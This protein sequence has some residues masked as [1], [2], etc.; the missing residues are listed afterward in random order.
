M[1]GSI[2]R[3]NQMEDMLEHLM[4]GQTEHFILAPWG[5]HC[6]QGQRDHHTAKVIRLLLLVFSPQPRAKFYNP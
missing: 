4:D 3:H 5:Y 1:G 2:P 6:K